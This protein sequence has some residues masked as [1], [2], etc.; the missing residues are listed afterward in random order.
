MS[1]SIDFSNKAKMREFISQL[2]QAIEM[3]KDLNAQL[4]K[5]DRILEERSLM[6][7]AA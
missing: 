3:A 6:K 4:D 7:K 5:I 2:D 1:A